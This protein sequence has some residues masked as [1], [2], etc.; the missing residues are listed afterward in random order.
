[1]LAHSD[2][3]ASR[4]LRIELIELLDYALRVEGSTGAEYRAILARDIGFIRHILPD[5][6]RTQPGA[7]IR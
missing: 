5:L 3:R 6:D 4:P 2:I 1:M 7:S